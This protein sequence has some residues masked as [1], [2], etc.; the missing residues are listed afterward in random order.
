VQFVG[1]AAGTEVDFLFDGGASTNYVSS[2][3]ARM[4]GLTVNPSDTNVR[5]G[6]GD[7]VFAQG[8]CFVHIKLGDYQDRVECYVLD[9]VTDL[10]MILGDTWLNMVRLPS[11]MTLKSASFKRMTR[12]LLSRLALALCFVIN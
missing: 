8:E 2:A 12:G 10:Q 3:F 9:M 1:K 4:H 5:S 11:I 6:T 7:S